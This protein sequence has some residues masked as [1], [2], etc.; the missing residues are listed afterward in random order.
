MKT[1]EIM[2]G[3]CLHLLLPD[4]HLILQVSEE[5]GTIPCV[6]VQNKIDLIDEAVVQP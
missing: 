1:A 6:L 3:V 2:L 4:W 5:C